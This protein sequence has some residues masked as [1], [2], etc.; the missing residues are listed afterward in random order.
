MIPKTYL[1]QHK[2]QLISVS[3]MIACWAFLS[4][5]LQ[6]TSL[7]TPVLVWDAFSRELSS[8]ELLHHCMWTMY[9][10]VIAFVLAMSIGVALGL[11]FGLNIRCNQFFDVWLITLLNMPALVIIILCYLWIGLSEVSAIT[12]VALNKIPNITVVVREGT[13][14]L[15]QKLMQM[16]QVFRLPMRFILWRIILPQLT[17][18]FVASARSGLALIWKIVL[19]L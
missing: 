13:R 17:P 4:I 11:I 8:G 7:P 1:A 9:R 2:L 18:Y 5:W 14:A 6:S 3:C 12:A 15:D 16:A 10:V 19:R